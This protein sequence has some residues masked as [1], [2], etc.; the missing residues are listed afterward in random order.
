[1]SANDSK[2]EISFKQILLRLILIPGNSKH[3]INNFT[4]L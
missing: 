1:M 4:M 3:S 2:T